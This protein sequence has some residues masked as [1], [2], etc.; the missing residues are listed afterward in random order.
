MIKIFRIPK[1]REKSLIFVVFHNFQM[2]LTLHRVH[3]FERGGLTQLGTD[4]CIRFF[5]LNQFLYFQ[6][7]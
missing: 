6:N 7:D 3:L 5:I 1:I 4:S 2:Q